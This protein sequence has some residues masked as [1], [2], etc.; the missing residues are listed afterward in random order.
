MFRYLW[1]WF[2]VAMQPRSRACPCGGR[3]VWHD[4]RNLPGGGIQFGGTICDACDFSGDLMGRT[5]DQL[6]SMWE[7]NPFRKGGRLHSTLSTFTDKP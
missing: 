3:L 7:G 2:K 6:R 5:E 4:S 1:L